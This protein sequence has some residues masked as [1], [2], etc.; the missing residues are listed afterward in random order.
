AGL[1]LILAMISFPLF[2]IKAQ[3]AKKICA[4]RAVRS[5]LTQIKLHSQERFF[6]S[7]DDLNESRD[8]S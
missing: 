3:I 7:R 8:R 2:L 5:R 1:R 4:G 6:F